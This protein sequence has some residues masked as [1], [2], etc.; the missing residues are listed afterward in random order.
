MTMICWCRHSWTVERTCCGWSWHWL[1]CT[2][3][4]STSTRRVMSCSLSVT[5]ATRPA[6]CVNINI[7]PIFS[8]SFTARD[9]ATDSYNLEHA[10]EDS[11]MQ[12]NCPAN[13]DWYFLVALFLCSACLSMLSLFLLNLC[14]SQFHIRLICYSSTGYAL[15]MLSMLVIALAI[16]AAWK[17]CIAKQLS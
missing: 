15:D 3:T 14:P 6:W 8:L 4:R 10:V 5:S 11:L 16:S 12:L 13:T 7:L 17:L 9:L 2:S 1:S